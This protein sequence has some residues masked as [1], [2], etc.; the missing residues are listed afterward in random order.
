MKTVFFLL[1]ALGTM[2][3]HLSGGWQVFAAG[4][5]EEKLK[6]WT[7]AVSFSAPMARHE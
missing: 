2:R 6:S 4:T 5:N 3:T 1:E 7:T